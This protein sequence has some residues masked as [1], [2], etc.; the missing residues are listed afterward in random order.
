M[1]SASLIDCTNVRSPRAQQEGCHRDGGRGAEPTGDRHLRSEDG[2]RPMLLC[3]HL[4]EAGDD[5][6]RNGRQRCTAAQGQCQRSHLDK[7]DGLCRA[8]PCHQERGEPADEQAGDQSDGGSD[9]CKH[10]QSARLW[11]GSVQQHNEHPFLFGVEFC[12]ESG[13][14][15]RPVATAG[16][17]TS[18]SPGDDC[19][20]DCLRRC[21]SAPT[22]LFDSWKRYFR[23]RTLIP[24]AIY[25]LIAG[26]ASFVVLALV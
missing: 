12:H 19:V 15:A 10:H 3:G 11:F 13:Q 22:W 23:T 24:L 4:V 6:D 20:V 5:R 16:Q 8:H 14:H 21:S 26:A 1:G 17:Q 25:C 7:Y 18:H 9:Q 2:G